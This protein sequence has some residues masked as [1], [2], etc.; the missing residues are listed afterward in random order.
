[1]RYIKKTPLENSLRLIDS[2]FQQADEAFKGAERRPTA[3]KGGA[4]PPKN[5][6]QQRDAPHG[7]LRQFLAS[8]QEHSRI[9]IKYQNVMYLTLQIFHAQEIL[10]HNMLHRAGGKINVIVGDNDFSHGLVQFIE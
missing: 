3:Q 5:P 2:A 8:P 1:M 10:K 4:H 7:T 6:I 9:N